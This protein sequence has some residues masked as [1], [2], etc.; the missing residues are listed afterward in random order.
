MKLTAFGTAC[1]YLVMLGVLTGLLKD[2]ISI[3][4]D[5]SAGRIGMT[6]AP[7]RE[8]DL[9][10]RQDDGDTPLGAFPERADISPAN[11]TLTRKLHQPKARVIS[12]LYSGF[13]VRARGRGIY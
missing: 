8:S 4:I 10:K 2:E 5:F 3:L 6:R 9:Q 7:T 11:Q 13:D 1:E 12:R